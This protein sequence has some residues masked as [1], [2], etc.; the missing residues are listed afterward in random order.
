MDTP[1]K[2][3]PPHALVVGG[4][5]MLRGVVLELA[6]RGFAVSVVARGLS[7]LEALAREAAAG[8]GLVH[9]VTVDYH[10][11]AALDRALAAACDRWGAIELAVVWIHR[12]APAAPMVVARWVGG[13]QRP[14]R[15]FHLLGSAV[16]DPSRPDPQRRAAYEALPHLVYR[17]VILGFVTEGHRSRWLTHQEIA[18][19]VVAAI[20]ADQPRFIVGTVE[21]W[22]RRP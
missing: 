16:A 8:G 19:G 15:F 7:R 11:T 13:P 4:T 10:D 1:L 21:P 14:G 6:A 17:E 20:D 2:T 5:G 9:P 3:N 22:D 12:T 18:A